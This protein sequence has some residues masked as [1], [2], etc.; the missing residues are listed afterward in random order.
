MHAPGYAALIRYRAD[1]V[2][3]RHRELGA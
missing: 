1:R 2:R 3:V